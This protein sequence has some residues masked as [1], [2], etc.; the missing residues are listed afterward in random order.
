MSDC[1]YNAIRRDITMI[2]ND[3]MSFAFQVQGLQGQRPSNIVFT[4]KETPE[5][6][7]ALFSV[8]FEDHIILR[9]YDEDN[10]VLT[11]IVRIPPELT[12]EVELGRYY[13]DLQLTVNYDIY[14][15]LK[16]RLTLEYQVTGEAV[17]PEPPLEYGDE[18]KYP[19]N[20]IPL[21]TVKIYTEQYISDIAAQIQA[22]LATED[23]Y[24]TQEM[25]AALVDINNIILY[26]SEALKTALSD[27]SPDGISLPD[28][29]SAMDTIN[30]DLSDISDAINSITGGSGK[31]PISDM[32]ALI[33]SG[34][35]GGGYSEELMITFP[36]SA[37]GDTYT[38]TDGNNETYTGTIPSSQ[39]VIVNL[40]QALTTYT[41]TVNNVSVYYTSG[42]KSTLNFTQTAYVI[43]GLKNLAMTSEDYTDQYG[44]NYKVMAASSTSNPYRA[45]DNNYQT[46]WYDSNLTIGNWIRLYISTPCK[47]KKFIL[48]NG[49]DNYRFKDFIFQGSDDGLSWDNIGSYE[50]VSGCW[51]D[52]YQMF[53]QEF[54]ANPAKNYNYY[55]WYVTSIH[56]GGLVQLYDVKF[57]EVTT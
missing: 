14:T 12:E 2:Q 22:I 45:F 48:L 42:G 47:V 4:C 35:G 20:T 55:R 29:P 18:I 16:G 5:I 26:L 54:T 43:D 44:I 28:M 24:N 1:F 41:V 8:S 56:E 7:E 23:K 52:E 21:G 13:Y 49:Y 31:I 9:S 27:D 39:I 25:S 33:I 30:N 36:S 6:N 50:W 3:T 15:L 51:S 57:T 34:G 10:D 53:A 38:V 40:K 46:E 19:V 37:V 32:A 11:Y 17:E